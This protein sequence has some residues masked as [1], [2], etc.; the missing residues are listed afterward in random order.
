MLSNMTSAKAAEAEAAQRPLAGF[1]TGAFT[2]RG[3]QVGF[4]NEAIAAL[5][6]PRIKWAPAAIG[7]GHAQAGFA[8]G[9]YGIS[10]PQTSPVLTD[11]GRVSTMPVY[12][13]H[14]NQMTRIRPVNPGGVGP[15]P[16]REPDPV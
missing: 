6:L 15:H 3:A 11:A 1:G 5:A 2:R 13:Q 7:Q 14:F 10:L 12:T 9:A 4:G 8:S 16:A